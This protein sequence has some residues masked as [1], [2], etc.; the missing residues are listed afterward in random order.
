MKIAIYDYQ[1]TRN[2]PAGSCHRAVIAGLSDEHDFSV[3][4]VEFDNP[5]PEKVSWTH[6]LAI[7]RPLAALFISFHASALI[8]W[9]KARWRKQRFAVVQSI[10]SNFGFGEIVYSHF[11]HRWF[12]KHRWRD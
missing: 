12:L 6:L 3:F 8:Q 5:R 9:W 11:C 1:V 7:R 4:S 2:N 10:E